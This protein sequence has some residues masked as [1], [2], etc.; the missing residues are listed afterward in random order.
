MKISTKDCILEEALNL[1][2]VNGFNGTSMSDIAGKVGITKAALYKHFI[3]KE[4]I[5]EEILRVGER[6]YEMKF[7]SAAKPPKIPDSGEELKELSLKQINYTIHEPYVKKYRRLF[8]I[9]QYHSDRIAEYATNHFITGLEE[10]YTLIFCEMMEK[11]ILKEGD[12][13]FLAFEY[14]T[15]VSVMIQQCDRLPSWEDV[16]MERINRHIDYFLQINL[17]K[18]ER[19]Q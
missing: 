16:A 2:S 14:L 1:F 6:R 19:V 17:R 9:E 18:K 3:S 10:L 4:E 15:P 5:L 7:G 13:S 11:G 8:T 12:P